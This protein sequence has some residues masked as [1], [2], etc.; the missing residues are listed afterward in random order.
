MMSEMKELND[1]S[2]KILEDNLKIDEQLI[3]QLSRFAYKNFNQWNWEEKFK[4]KDKAIEVNRQ[5]WV[6]TLKHNRSLVNQLRIEQLIK[7]KNNKEC[8]YVGKRKSKRKPN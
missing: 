1:E 6:T 2:I 7:Q 3:E 5:L 8:S 4:T